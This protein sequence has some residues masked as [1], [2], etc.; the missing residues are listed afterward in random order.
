MAQK[1]EDLE[2]GVGQWPVEGGSI[3]PA[4][5]RLAVLRSQRREHDNGG[6]P[7]LGDLGV[8]RSLAA[9]FGAVASMVGFES[10]ST[11]LFR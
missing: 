5:W 1:L 4:Y 2:D 6:D 8:I 9:Q 3:L 10:S 7:Q 11:S